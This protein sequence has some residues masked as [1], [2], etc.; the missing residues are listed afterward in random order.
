M[1]RSWSAPGRSWGRLESLLGSRS[2]AKEKIRRR[3]FSFVSMGGPSGAV[4][5]R[6]WPSWGPLGPSVFRE[7]ENSSAHF[8]LLGRP[9]ALLGSPSALL[10]PSWGPLGPPV[11]REGAHDPACM[12]GGVPDPT[13]SGGRVAVEVHFQL[14][15][16]LSD[17]SSGRGGG[18]LGCLED[19]FGCHAQPGRAGGILRLA[20]SRGL[21][22]R[23]WGSVG[24]LLG[25]LEAS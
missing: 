9:G 15:A 10:G 7:G 25:F 8:F 17:S 14:G 19:C 24:A 20:A 6:R 2:S 11:V 4:S 22:R 5:G 13:G 16:R 21:P 3:I 1:K 23:S 12:S 18:P